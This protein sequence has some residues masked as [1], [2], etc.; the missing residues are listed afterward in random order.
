MLRR[1]GYRVAAHSSVPEALDDFQQDPRGYDLVITDQAMPWMSGT[2][3]AERMLMLRPKLPI[4][5]CAG[6]TDEVSEERARTVGVRELLRKPFTLADVSA[7]I[8]RALA[9]AED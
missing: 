7:T 4:I 2:E 3:L 9:R 6:Y 5:L 1:L 8:R